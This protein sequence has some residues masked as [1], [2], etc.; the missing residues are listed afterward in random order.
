MQSTMIVQ[1]A[2]SAVGPKN[3]CC[4]YIFWAVLGYLGGHRFYLGYIGTVRACLPSLLARAQSPARLVSPAGLLA[5]LWWMLSTDTVTAE[6]LAPQCA[7]QAI[8]WLLT[9]GVFG[10]GW[11]VDAC[12]IPS[13]T[14]Q[15]N[16][17]LNGNTTTIITN[18]VAPPVMV[19]APPVVMM[20]QP[21]VVV[22]QQQ[23][24]QQYP[25]QYAPPAQAYVTVQ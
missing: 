24:P 23:Y 11:L 8:L 1:S 5:S 19:M 4:A 16:R 6:R 3:V 10:I 25:Q 18:T 14:A 13:L 17:L 15:M 21:Q 22:H 20:Q 12:L 9:C 7:S 2:P